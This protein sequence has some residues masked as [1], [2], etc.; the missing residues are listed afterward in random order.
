M[1]ARGGRDCRRNRRARRQCRE[2]PLEPPPLTDRQ[3]QFTQIFLGKVSELIGRNPVLPESR[4][5]F[6]KTD[7]CQPLFHAQPRVR[8]AG[9]AKNFLTC[10]LG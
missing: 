10:S 5:A 4:D 7:R 2:F 8:S 1:L 6:R 3:T 9:H